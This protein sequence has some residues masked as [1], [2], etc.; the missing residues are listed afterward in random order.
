MTLRTKPE[1][2]FRCPYPGKVSA[3]TL[4]NVMV[5]QS[6]RGWTHEDVIKAIHDAQRGIRYR[7]TSTDKNGGRR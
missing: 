5:V 7:R 1:T 4:H 3:R 2:S 6:R